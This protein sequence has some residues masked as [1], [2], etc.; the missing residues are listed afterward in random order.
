M[1]FCLE[2]LG[3]NPY[4]ILTITKDVLTHQ[5]RI[6]KAYNDPHRGSLLGVQ[7]DALLKT[8]QRVGN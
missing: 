6:L 2:A 8:K 4:L 5:N 3:L 7:S 1:T